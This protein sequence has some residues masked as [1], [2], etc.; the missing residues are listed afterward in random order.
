[1]KD[2]VC[3]IDLLP[4]QIETRACEWMEPGVAKKL[5]VLTEG[6]PPRDKFV[7]RVDGRRPPID[8]CRGVDV[9]LGAR[10]D[11]HFD[12]GLPVI[13]PIPPETRSAVDAAVVPVVAITSWVS[14]ALFSL[15]QPSVPVTSARETGSRTV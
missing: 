7:G 5:I 13:G 8:D 6:Q 12:I 11:L 10:A 9:Q 3:L 2:V 14:S 4:R 15:S 1:M